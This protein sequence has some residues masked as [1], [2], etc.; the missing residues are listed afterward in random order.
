VPAG[1]MSLMADLYRSLGIGSFMNWCNLNSRPLVRSRGI[2]FSS[3]IGGKP[4]I[5]T[6]YDEEN[7]T[8][9]NTATMQ[10]SYA[11]C[12]LWLCP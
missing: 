1:I 6:D 3:G 9:Y 7:F 2:V 12:G 8:F 10:F 5:V 4:L 11:P